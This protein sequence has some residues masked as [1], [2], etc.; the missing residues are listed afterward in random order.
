[1]SAINQKTKRQ[2]EKS[3]K[4]MGKGNCIVILFFDGDTRG[5]VK[6]IQLKALKKTIIT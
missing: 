3:K 1:M 4:K 5:G 2:R 6:E